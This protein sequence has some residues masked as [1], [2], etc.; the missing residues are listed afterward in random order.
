MEGIRQ[1]IIQWLE[2]KAAD[3]A[4][5]SHKAPMP[6]DWIPLA[7]DRMVAV[8]P[9]GHPLADRGSYPLAQCAQEDFIMPALGRD[10]DVLGLLETHG[11]E[12]KIA[13]TTLDT[14]SALAMIQ[15][16]LGMSIMNELITKSWPGKVAILPLDPPQQLTLGVA[17]P[18]LPRA[19]PAVKAFLQFAVQALT[20][21]QAEG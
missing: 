15:N 11:L 8:L 9:P 10:D 21:G 5:F 16:D 17:V 6:Y 14:V 3:L 2:D 13:F 1:E 7:E 19:A 4:F 20:Q 18:S 12:P